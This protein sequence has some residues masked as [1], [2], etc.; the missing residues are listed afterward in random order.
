MEQIEVLEKTGLN[1]SVRKEEL[2]TQSGIIVPNKVAL[3]RD[4]TN[5]ILSVMGDGYQEYQNSELLELLYRINQSTGLDVCNGGDF[6]GGQKVWFQFK[7][8][9]LR[10]GDDKVEGYLTGSNS[11]DGSTSL[12]FGNSTITISCMNS[13]FAATKQLDSK[14]RH[15]AN[16]KP[17][18][19][20]ILFGIDQLLIDE[21]KTF[22]T[23]KILS[24][25]PMKENLKDIIIATVFDVPEVK[26]VKN[27]DLSTRMKNKIELFDMDWTKE[28]NGKGNT[29]WGAMSSITSYTSHHINK[30]ED[31]RRELK[32]FGRS[33]DI[34]RAVW[35]K[36]T[37][38]LP[39][40]AMAY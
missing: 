1:W 16:L 25:T 13:Y 31:R 35:K 11:F 29:L 27:T 36:V 18:V 28:I 15:S 21:K 10:L 33:G 8:N 20:K 7:T 30:R 34:D 38:Q 17:R 19:E 39:A 4:D 6:G 3:V 22:E 5:A 9:D 26:D 14:I 37:A 12:G 32:M 23:I 40:L 2:T 24:E